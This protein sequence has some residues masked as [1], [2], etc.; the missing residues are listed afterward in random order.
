MA[1]SDEDAAL[2][3]TLRAEY[4]A[5]EH[6]T[7]GS[8]H[9]TLVPDRLVDLMALAGTPDEV[10]ARVRSIAELP[11]IRRVILLPQVPD[12]EFVDEVMARV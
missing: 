2:V 3:Q 4:D 11:E 7:A 10:A 9:R 6:A 5:F 8:R 12:P 1:L